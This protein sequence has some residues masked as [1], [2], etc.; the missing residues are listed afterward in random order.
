M[1]TE[2]PSSVKSFRL[3]DFHVHLRRPQ[4]YSY[5]REYGLGVEQLVNRMD[6]E[7]ID[8]SVLLPL[9]S[10]EATEFFL[11]EEAV[12]ARDI[13]PERL[14]AFVS[15]DPRRTKASERA[16]AWIEQ[17]DCRGFG[18]LKNELCFDDSRNEAIYEMC[19][20]YS[21]PLVFHIDPTLCRDEVGLPRLAAMVAKYANVSFVGHGPGFWSAISSDDDRR[22]GYPDGPV[23]PGGALDRLFAEHGNLYGEISAGSG[24]NALTRDPEFTQ[25]F[26]ERNHQRLIFGTDYLQAGQKLPQVEW[27]ASV[28]MPI[29]WRQEIAFGTALRIMGM[30]GE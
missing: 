9:E 5:P 26:L 2:Q 7:G 28:D 23:T 21:L 22:G 1:A 27:L 24:H 16:A 19:D 17:H 6:R 8:K 11:T 13:Y 15:I 29:A 10:P 30:A 4:P 12:A 18:E 14:I 20:H 3:I 25:G